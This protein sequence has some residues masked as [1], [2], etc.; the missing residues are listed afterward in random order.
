MKN[1]QLIEDFRQ[2]KMKTQ[3]C[4]KDLA[5]NEWF[6]I[7]FWRFEIPVILKI[8]VKIFPT[9]LSKKFSVF[10][11]FD[12]FFHFFEEKKPE[13]ESLETLHSSTMYRHCFC[14]FSNFFLKS[15]KF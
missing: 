4:W 3:T 7:L 12:S 2:S 15:M 1:C 13:N 11:C 6:A 14:V 10:G 8:S 5:T 9:H